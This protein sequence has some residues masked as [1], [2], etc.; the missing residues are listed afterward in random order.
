MQSPP[1]SPDNSFAEDDTT[2]IAGPSRLYSVPTPHPDFWFY[3]GSIIL[4]V[5]SCL[6]R[7]H[8]T[9][10]ANHSEIFADLFTVP[11]PEGEAVEMIEGCRIVHLYDD[12]NDFVD[13]L[14]AVYQPDYFDSLSADSDLETV[15]TF[16]QGILRLST[17]YIIRYLRQRCISV[18]LTKFPAT[19]D[20]YTAKCASKKREKYKPENLMCAIAL[21]RQNNVL[22]ILPYAFYCIARLSHK[23]ILKERPT[24]IS[25]KDKAL[26]LVGRERLHWAQTSLSHVFLLNFQRAP[27]CQS[28][29]CAVAR[30]PHAEWHVLDCMKSPNPLRA[31][32]TWDYLNVCSDCVTYCKI[33]HLKGRQE[34]WDRLPDLFELPTWEELRKTQNM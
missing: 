15:L 13:L 21:A 29:L 2:T 20:D 23:R 22:E 30:G 28:P 19:L 31:Y 34:V 16:I 6:F 33:R 26:T 11:Q 32:D 27:L 7:V 10:L 24:D 14:N 8:Q 4:S 17:K 12:E 25:W 5:E 9:I 18:L 3:D 1:E